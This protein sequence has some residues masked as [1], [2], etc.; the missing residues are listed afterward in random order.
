MVVISC[1]WLYYDSVPIHQYQCTEPTSITLANQIII[2]KFY[3]VYNIAS[4]V[5]VAMCCFHLFCTFP[6]TIQH[7]GPSI[8]SHWHLIEY[9]IVHFTDISK[10]I[11]YYKI[12][13]TFHWRSTSHSTF[14][15]TFDSFVLCSTCNYVSRIVRSHQHFLLNCIA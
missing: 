12:H 14:Q 9:F 3:Q 2:V 1:D 4:T 8:R 13:S 5:H 7:T 10:Y 6:L 15:N 11:S